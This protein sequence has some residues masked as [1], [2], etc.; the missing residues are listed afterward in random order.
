MSCSKETGFSTQQIHGS[1][2]DTAVIRPLAT[3]IYQ[4]STF[5]FESTAQGAARFAGKEDGYIYTR[6]GNPN[7]DEAA[8]KIAMLEGAEA[9]VATGSG[10]GAITATIW[11]LMRVGDHLLA[12]NSLYGCTFAFFTHGLTR[13]GVEVSLVDFSDLEAVRRAMRPNTTVLYFESECNPSLKLLDVETIAAIAHEREKPATVVCDNTFLT[14]A[15]DR[16]IEH[17][18][19]VVLHRAT[20]Y[21][22]GHGDVV[23]GAVCASK[24]LIREIAMFGIKDMTGSVLGPNEAFLLN[25]GLKTLDIRMKK[26]CENAMRVARFLEGHRAVRRVLYPGL[27]SHPQHE[28]AKETLPNG[29]GGMISFELDCDLETAERFINSL[30]LCS[31]AVSLGD[32]ETLIEHPASMTHSAYTREARMEAGIL[33]SMIRL[34][35]GLEDAA[36]II[37]DLKTS[38]DRI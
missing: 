27:A 6:L 10:M 37:A 22:N 17:G 12:D 13:Y 1:H 36:D 25:R 33:D 21:L 35:V 14:P 18:V 15:L 2:P 26:H 38:L 28:R 31:L 4:T 11:T 32:T 24:A 23:A 16:P 5:I 7:S 3:P 29:F 19:D 30:R 8:G 34:S 20:K 9:G